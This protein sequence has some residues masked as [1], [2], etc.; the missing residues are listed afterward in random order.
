MVMAYIMKLTIVYDN[1]IYIPN[2]GLK[3]DWGFSCVI[4]TGQKTVL[5]DTGAKGTILLHNM[6]KLAIDP[7]T[8]DIIVISHEHWDHNGGLQALTKYIHNVS[9]YGLTDEH[10][11]SDL[12]F[13]S[14][15]KPLYIADRIWTTGKLSGVV[16]EQSLVLRGEYGWCVLV[17]C[18]HPGV[19]NILNAA[20]T[21][22]DIVGLVG[23]FH[24]FKAFSL[25]EKLTYVCPCH[26]T[27]NKK[28]IEKLYPQKY[29]AGGVG[30]I[31]DI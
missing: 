4:E 10:L 6:E 19:E 23:G 14:V 5:F 13:Y 27:Q 25:L 29:I 18:S 8:I 17:G 15:E 28:T 11:P 12:T 22:G 1:E 30:Q 31:I 24:G 2:R 16:D 21:K 7:G 3:S 26:C 9:L 20:E